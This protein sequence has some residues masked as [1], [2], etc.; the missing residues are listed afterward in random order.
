MA[1]PIVCVQFCVGDAAP[2]LMTKR[3]EFTDGQTIWLGRDARGV[4][5]SFT[6]LVAEWLNGGATLVGHNIAYD[7]AALCAHDGALTP[8]IF[9]AY[10]ES[11]ITDTMLRQKLADI[12]RGKHR[13]FF[14]GPIYIPLN[15]D[16]GSVGNRHGFRVDKDD[17]WRVHYDLLDDVTLLH[18]PAFRATVPRLRKDAP[19]IGP[20]GQ[21]EMVTLQGLDAITYGL[22]DPVATRAAF[23]GQAERYHPDLLCDEFQQARKF[24]ALQLASVWGLRTSLRGVLSLERGARQRKDELGELLASARDEQGQPAPLIKT[25]TKRP[26][27]DGSFDW[28]RDTKAAK[29]RM[30][31][32]CARDG[33]PLRLTKGGEKSAPDVCLDSDACNSSGDPLLEAYAEYSSMAK[34]LSND[35]EMLRRGVVVPIHT[36]FDLAD[37]GRVTS[38]K[39][40][41]MNPRRLAGVRECFVPRGYVE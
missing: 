5:Y 11:R 28:S 1:P 18:W 34:V 27:L 38:A 29:A 7:M 39:P 35:V 22:G 17:P 19:V 2:L 30:R 33:I 6:S 37:T 4:P 40:N 25:K 41:V 32:A 20:D 9:R 13:G 26:K 16:L 8:L 3:G 14:H 12:G 36:H 23:R 24:W 21:P 15:Y 10:R 31:E